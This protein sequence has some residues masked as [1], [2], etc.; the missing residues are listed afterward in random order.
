[1]RG[2]VHASYLHVVMVKICHVLFKLHEWTSAAG[3]EQHLPCQVDHGIFRRRVGSLPGLGISCSN[4]C[5]IFA[6]VSRR[7]LFSRG[8]APV[9]HQ[10][11]NRLARDS[12]QTGQ[13]LVHCA[14][15]L[16]ASTRRNGSP[17]FFLQG[18]RCLTQYSGGIADQRPRL[19]R[20]LALPHRRA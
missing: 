2:M 20:D 12:K 9:L 5:R 13:D 1:M 15:A 4:A 3:V 11:L 16:R 8:L 19:L 7:P 17:Q 18:T 14:A 10:S 6:S